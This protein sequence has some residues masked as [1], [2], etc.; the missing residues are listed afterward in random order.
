MKPAPLSRFDDRRR[1][2]M[3]VRADTRVRPYV[4]NLT[5]RGSAPDPGSS[6]AGT[7]GPAP[8]LAGA[9][10]APSAIRRSQREQNSRDAPYSGFNR[11][12]RGGEMLSA[13]LTLPLSLLIAQPPAMPPGA[14]NARV[15]GRV[16]E[17]ETGAP[18]SG[19]FVLL[20]PVVQSFPA[21]AMGPPQALTD[22]NGEFAVERVWAGRYRIEIQKTGFA[23]LSDITDAPTLNIEAEQSVTGLAF[24]MKKGSVI[25]GRVVDAGGEPLSEITVA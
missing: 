14:A 12:T 18:V 5:R 11:S 17:A 22:T 3:I 15:T 16:V 8:L 20:V 10:C 21:A 7:P 2:L 9:P 25:A 23:P 4:S 1:Y 24:A 19:A 13:L 6:L